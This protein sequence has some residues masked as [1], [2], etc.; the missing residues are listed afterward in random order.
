VNPASGLHTPAARRQQAQKK[1][2]HE[3]NRDPSIFCWSRRAESNR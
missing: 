2:P 1:D 3:F